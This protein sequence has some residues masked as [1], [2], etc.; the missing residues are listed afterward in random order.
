MTGGTVLAENG[1]NLGLKIH[2]P[3]FDEMGV[4]RKAARI[5]H[6][7][8]GAK[9]NTQPAYEQRYLHTSLF[10]GWLS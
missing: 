1:L 4:F 8:T 9:P 2:L 7:V 10:N 3:G 5:L 6:R